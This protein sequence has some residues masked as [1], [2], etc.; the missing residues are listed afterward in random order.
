MVTEAKAA[1]TKPVAQQIEPLAEFHV[2][3]A[4]AVAALGFIEPGADEDLAVELAEGLH[5]IG[6]VRFQV[7]QGHVG[8]RQGEAP[9]GEELSQF[10]GR[11]V[12]EAA[13]P[14]DLAVA[15]FGG[16]VQGGFEVLLGLPAQRVELERDARGVVLAHRHSAAS[17][18]ASPAVSSI[19]PW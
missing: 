10:G 18:L 8:R 3:R 2:V 13:E 15:G 11:A 1:G 5:H 19:R 14:L 17:E 12:P 4:T 7:G 16:L 6:R 9:F